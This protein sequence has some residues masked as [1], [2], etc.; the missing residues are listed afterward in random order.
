MEFMS[1]I[2]GSR[3]KECMPVFVCACVYS[4]TNQSISRRLEDKVI[5][6]PR[7]QWLQIHS[8]SL[9]N[10]CLRVL[11]YSWIFY[12]SIC[13]LT[14]SLIHLLH[15]LESHDFYYH[16]ARLGSVFCEIVMGFRQT[17]GVLQKRVLPHK[18]CT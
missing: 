9:V 8:P 10:P 14:F 2:L 17:Y 7:G 5:T 18:F 15:I 12:F 11:V 13:A 1:G 3:E 4:C 6:S 16:N